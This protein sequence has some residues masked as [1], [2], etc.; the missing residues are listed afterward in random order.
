MGKTENQLEEVITKA[1]TAFN[2]RNIDKALSNMH[3]KF[4]RLESRLHKYIRK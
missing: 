4:K 1:Y 2:E 3:A